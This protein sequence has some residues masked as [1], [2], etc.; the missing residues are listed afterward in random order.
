MVGPWGLL[1]CQNYHTIKTNVHIHEVNIV[2]RRIPSR[3]GM[4]G[5]RVEAP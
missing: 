1:Q 4:K 5:A 2:L 3:V